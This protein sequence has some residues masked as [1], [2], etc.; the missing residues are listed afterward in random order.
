M[1]R[2]LINGM[3]GIGDQLLQ[4]PF[5]KRLVMSGNEVWIQTPIPEF[6][7]DI[8]N[9]HFVRANTTLRT[10]KK[11][12]SRTQVKYEEVPRDLKLIT[13]KIF[14]GIKDLE[15]GSVFAAGRRQFGVEPV[16]LDMPHFQ[17]P[18]KYIPG[19]I[20]KLALIRPTTERKEW[21]NASR[22]PL[23]KHIDEVS[24]ALQARGYFCI[25]VADLEPGA[26]WIPDVEPFAHLKIH[27]GELS[28]TELM[29]LVERA[30]IVVTGPCLISQAAFAYRRPTIFL[31]GGNGGCNHHT[32]ITDPRIM[33][34]HNCLFVYPDKYCMCYEM[35]HACNKYISNVT[36][37]I[38]GW[39]NA[40][41]L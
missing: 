18:N 28:I 13:K 35:K 1:A 36:G 20:K 25:S 30:D 15:N 12:E 7:Q 24:K 8:P 3:Q 11:N 38:N 26:E 17:L 16:A 39:L 6:Y 5:I 10:Q 34:L 22:G 37:K 29:A 2:Y 23:N 27:K 9:V 33:S 4:R 32:K 41:G 14:Y 19:N 40:Q 31:G 21:H